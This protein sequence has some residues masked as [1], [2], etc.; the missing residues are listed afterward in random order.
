M[1][2]LLLMMLQGATGIIPVRH[3]AGAYVGEERPRLSWA[4]FV[5]G[6]WQSQCDRYAKE[7]HGFREGAIRLH[8]QYLWTCYHRTPNYG[9][10]LIGRNDYLFEPFFVDDYY[11]GCMYQYADSPDE[12]MDIFRRTASRL[13]K[14]QEILEQQGT[15]LFVACLPGKDRIYPQYL[16][17]RGNRTR[18]KYLT[19]ADTYP[20]LFDSCGV[21]YVDVCHWF[22]RLNGHVPYRLFT[23]TGTHWSRIACAYAFDS[24]MRYMQTFGPA[25]APVELGE[26]YYA[27]RR[28]PDA[29][30][31]ELL[32]KIFY[33]PTERNQY[34][35]ITVPHPAPEAERP[36]LVDIGD[37]FFWTVLYNYPIQDLFS[38]FRYWYYFSTIYYDSDHDN[39]ENI[40][41]V[42][43]LLSA[44]YVMLSYCT[45]Q[46]YK[47]GNGFV[48]RALLELCYDADEI[49][50]V[51][52]S[53]A[54]DT[55]NALSVDE[56]IDRDLE[57]L[58]PALA[59]D[60][61][62]KRCRRLSQMAASNPA[63]HRLLK[64]F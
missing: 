41:L 22:D 13:A 30:L 6:E 56:R 60:H 42:D 17:G 55:T 21:R 12:M 34:V 15:H 25:I 3:L 24:I 36:S 16:P 48:N 5:S 26:P 50:A 57:T 58:F 1:A 63:S 45:V 9:S 32:N 27:S 14:V 59:E 64:G 28:E 19:A 43:Q 39:V 7:H 4:G 52:D 33:I 23:Q 38:H 31:D 37:S 61:P 47:L 11:E 2:L 35:D 44:D 54:A 18:T 10:V 53:L 20:G 49:A 40:D 29:D 62:A 51:R 8:N 46:L